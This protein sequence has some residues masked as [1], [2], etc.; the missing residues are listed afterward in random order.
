MTKKN[1]FETVFPNANKNNGITFVEEN[2]N[3]KKS[4][5]IV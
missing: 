2:L 4:W 5:V 3:N 1:M